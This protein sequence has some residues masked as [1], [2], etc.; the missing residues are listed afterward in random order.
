MSFTIIKTKKTNNKILKVLQDKLGWFWLVYNS[1]LIHT[2]RKI[3]E[4]DYEFKN[5]NVN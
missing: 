2:C 3:E 1:N 4:A 5:F